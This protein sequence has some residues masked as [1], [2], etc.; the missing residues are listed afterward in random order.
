MPSLEPASPTSSSPSDRAAVLRELALL[1]LRLGT[2][3]FGG[4][5]AH[6]ALMEDEVVRRR[7]WLTREEFVDLL[8]AA[9]LIPGPNSTELAIHIGHRRGGWPGLLVAGVCFILP[10]FLI[11]TSFA[12]AYSRFG[13]LPD[14]SALLSGVKAVIIAVVLQALW[15]LS[16]TVVKT[17][18]A[19]V[20]ALCSVS[21]AFLGVNE[22]LLLLLSGLGVLAWRAVEHRRA[23][24]PSSNSMVSPWA[25]M[26][27]LGGASAAVPFTQQ[28]LFLFFL[29]VGSVLYGSGYVLLAF[30]R[31]D[32]VERLGWLSEA[33]LLDAVAVGQVTPGPVFTTATFIG[34][35]LGGMTGA[36]VATV[37]IFLPAFFFVALS[38]PLVPRLRASWAAGAFLDGVNVASLALMAVVTW[39]LGRAAL[40]DAWTV[41]LA[42]ASAVLLLRFRVN[43]AWLVLG[44]GAVGW[45]VKSLSAG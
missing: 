42:I 1:F 10:A 43:S 8:G 31:A 36:V 26:L 39:Q 38:G 41:G 29:K 3:A 19:A 30:L 11:V 32:L 17:K 6:I 9:N 37:G 7:R 34:Y 27:P 25:L 35:V 13:T 4:P 16:L 15:G 21:A 14:V 40:V 33:Q 23:R 22:L 24:G 44:G 18:L 45:L 20:V 28:G 2:T 5:A 12:W